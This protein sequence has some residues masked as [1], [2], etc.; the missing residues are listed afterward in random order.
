[1][2]LI[3]S[4]TLLLIDVFKQ[5]T[6]EHKVTYWL[7]KADLHLQVMGTGIAQS[8]WWLATCWSVQGSNPSGGKIFHPCPDWPW[9]PPTLL[10]NG[11]WFFPGGG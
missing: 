6:Q 2:M 9:G 11:Y 1:M 5:L 8:V 4:Y 7:F 10:Y 3:F